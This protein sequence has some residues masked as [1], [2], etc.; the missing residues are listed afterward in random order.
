MKGFCYIALIIG[1]FLFYQQNP[2]Y[3]IVI[4]VLFF[5]VYIFYKSR[6]STSG[7][8]PMSFFAGRT[9]HQDTKVDDLITLMMVQQLMNSN[10]HSGSSGS[11]SSQSHSQD[12][13]RIEKIEQTKQEILD[14]LRD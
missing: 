2:M 8:G 14:L 7:N 6:T 13:E 10:H 4:I 3:A 1:F 11:N 12:E 5:G 9:N